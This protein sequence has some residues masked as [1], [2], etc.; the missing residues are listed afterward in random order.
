MPGI[1]DKLIGVGLKGLGDTAKDIIKQVADNKLA[2]IEAQARIDAEVNRHEEAMAAQS[3]DLEKAYL[4]SIGS[5]QD[6]NVKVQDSDK[7]S[8]M[9]KN[10][11]Y[12]IDLF[13]TFLWGG[14]TAYLMAV[15]LNLVRKD[16]NVDYTAVT[17]VWG[18][19][20]GVFTQ[21]LSFHRGSSKGSEDKQKLLDQMVR[22][23]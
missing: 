23:K 21:V 10:M 14:L 13:V 12:L 22:R 7:A 9:A 20:T 15:M 8:W 2:P 5:A 6:M 16:V 3:A 11:A 17:A 18:A 1:I 19:V 4:Q